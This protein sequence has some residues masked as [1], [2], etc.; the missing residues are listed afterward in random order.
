MTKLHASFRKCTPN[1]HIRPLYALVRN[2]NG[3]GAPLISLA[4]LARNVSGRGVPLISLAAL[5]RN[6]S[7]RGAPTGINFYMS[8]TLARV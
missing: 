1:S 7:G 6:V 2:V 4:A 3:R 8:T 5:T